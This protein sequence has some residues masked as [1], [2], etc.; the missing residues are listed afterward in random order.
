MT[1]VC[2]KVGD[3]M[4]N[5]IPV[6]VKH[7]NAKWMAEVTK[8]HYNY[9]YGLCGKSNDKMILYELK[10]FDGTP[11]MGLWSEHEIKVI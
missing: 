5:E 3:L 7:I 8:I 9:A 10:D 1:I 2:L 4:L 11:L 6:I